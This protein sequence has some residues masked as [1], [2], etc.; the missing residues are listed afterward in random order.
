MLSANFVATG[1]VRRF[2]GLAMS[3]ENTLLNRAIRLYQEGRPSDAEKIFRQLLKSHPENH[4]AM[5]LRMGSASCSRLDFSRMASLICYDLNI[6]EGLFTLFLFRTFQGGAMYRIRITLGV[7]L[8]SLILSILPAAAENYPLIIRGKVTMQD[9]SP[10]PFHAGIERICSDYSGSRPGPLTDKNGEY[11]WR[12]DVDPMRT[13]S[14][15]LRATHAGYVSSSI[16]ISAL[17]GYLDTMINLDPLVLTSVA[18]DPY[19]IIIPEERIPLRAKSAVKAA[20][21]ALDANNYPE[22]RRQ[23]QA[24]VDA[25]SKFSMGWHALGVLLERENALKEARE[26]FE[27]AIKT[28]AKYLPPYMTLTHLCIR[29]KQWDH[30][31]KTAD[32]LIKADKKRAYPDAYLHL[33]VARYGLNDFDGAVASVQE[34]VR[35][36]P[37]HSRMPR[38]E[39]VYGRILQAKGDISGAREHIVRYLMLDKAAPDTDLIRQNLRS[40]DKNEVP[41]RQAELEYP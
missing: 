19:A 5:S 4:T 37:N 10:P 16:D 9:G 29:D 23:F 33:A 30:A 32:A 20:M 36:D 41:E 35:L 8:V 27:R 6:P 21:K 15:V 24:A 17:N 1:P 7:F 34:A 39:Y 25:D 22:A 28:D 3:Q 12:M 11:L 38:V 14:C 18:D 26:A 31:A 2:Q 40:L 13:R